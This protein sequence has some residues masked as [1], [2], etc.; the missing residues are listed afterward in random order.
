M[1]QSKARSAAANWRPFPTSNPWAAW[2]RWPTPP[3]NPLLYAAGA[4]HAGEAPRF[5]NTGFQ[6]AS[7]S[8]RSV[9]WG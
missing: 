3:T 5:V 9:V 7:I 1:P 4:V 6:S 8:M 2:P